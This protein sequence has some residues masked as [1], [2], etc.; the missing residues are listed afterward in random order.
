MNS[1]H[2]LSFLFPRKLKEAINLDYSQVTVTHCRGSQTVLVTWCETGEAL[3][4]SRV[5]RSLP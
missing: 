1:S 4:A 2:P 5:A 3:F